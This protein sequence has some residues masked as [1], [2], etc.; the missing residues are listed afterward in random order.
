M[1]KITLLAV[2][3]TTAAF[4]VPA[5]AQA[6]NPV[7]TNALEEPAEHIT[8]DGIDVTWP[9]SLGVIGCTTTTTTISFSENTNETATGSGTG[10]AQGNPVIPTHTGPCAVQSSGVPIDVTT[11]TM[12]SFDLGHGEG[13]MA[14]SY[15]FDFTHPVLGSIMCNFIGHADL[16]Y[17]TKSDRIKL[18]HGSLTGTQNIPPCPTAGTTTG[19]FTITDEF[20]ERAELH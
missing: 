15:T 4:A 20:G 17:E 2:I 5:A 14:F 1:T 6:S 7:V 9:T 12:T 11:I 13:T 19:E 10:I 16:T 8:L 3:A 18:I